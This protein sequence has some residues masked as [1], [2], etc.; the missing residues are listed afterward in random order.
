MP[1][2]PTGAIAYK[3]T[4]QFTQDTVPKGLLSE[5]TTKAGTWGMLTIESGTLLYRIT[6]HGYEAEHVLEANRPGVIVA[7]QPH[8]IS[9]MGDVSFHVEFYRVPELT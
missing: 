1:K 9:I 4:P 8:H 6:E 2:L 3:Q 7:E 5:H